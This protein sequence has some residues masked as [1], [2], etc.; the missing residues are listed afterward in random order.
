M[1]EGDGY[2]E[3]PSNSQVGVG[4]DELRTT[5]KVRAHLDV[6]DSVSLVS[7]DLGANDFESEVIC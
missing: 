6:D 5:R 2:F 3:P 4:D 7:R 1:S